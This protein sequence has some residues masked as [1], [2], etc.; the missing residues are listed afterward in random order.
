[1]VVRVK[2]GKVV[3]MQNVSTESGCRPGTGSATLNRCQDRRSA[4]TGRRR[5]TVAVARYAGGATTCTARTAPEQ[6]GLTP[7][8]LEVARMD[9]FCGRDSYPT[10]YRLSVFVPHSASGS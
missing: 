7:S 8:D 1:M 3:A 6:A 10:T 9:A 2:V 4:R 5:R